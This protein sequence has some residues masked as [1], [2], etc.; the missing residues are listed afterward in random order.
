[1]IYFTAD[2]H[3]FHQGIIK[4]CNRPFK[5]WREM[6]DKIINRHNIV[7][8][9]NDIVYHIGDFAMIRKDELMKLEPI[10]KRLN[11]THHLIL[12]NHDEGNPFTYVRFGFTSVHTALQVEEFILIHDPA[13][14]VAVDR[15]QKVLCGHIHDLAKFPAPNVLNVGVDIFG[16]LPVSIDEVRNEFQNR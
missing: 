9:K 1:M 12:G 11:G 8:S 15:N 7:V 4:Y 14:A 3:F 13:H 16:F 6:N 10:L 5:S 2:Q